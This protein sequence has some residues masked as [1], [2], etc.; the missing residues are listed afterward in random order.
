VAFQTVFKRY[1]KKYIL[2]KE[3]KE[4]ILSGMQ[5]YME[6]DKYGRTSIRNT[7]RY[8]NSKKSW[9]WV[10]Y[11]SIAQ[12]GDG[13]DS[14]SRASYSAIAFTGGNTVII[15][16]SGGNS[17]IDSDGGYKYTGGKVLAIMPQGG[18]SNE[19]KHCSNFSSI[20]KSQN[21]NLTANSYATVNISG[22]AVASVKMPKN[23]NAIVIYLGS[24][25]ATISSATSSAG[26][27]NS[28]GVFWKE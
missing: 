24:N 22:S 1:E 12:G 7:Y 3:Q 5:E 25:S 13:V 14:N 27:E 23:I 6:L 11:N 17:A 10:D 4:K 8:S 28:N 9:S 19:S 15:S 2:T 21:V 16:T 18:M 20:G 26:T